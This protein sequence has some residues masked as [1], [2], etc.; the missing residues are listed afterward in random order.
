MLIPTTAATVERA[1]FSLKFVKND[2]RS[3]MSVDPMNALML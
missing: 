1:D 3:T 2:L